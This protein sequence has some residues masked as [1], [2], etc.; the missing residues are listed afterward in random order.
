MKKI[1]NAFS[2]SGNQQCPKSVFLGS[3]Y[4]WHHQDLKALIVAAIISILLGIPVSLIFYI[5]ADKN[6]DVSSECS[7]SAND[8]CG[9]RCTVKNSGRKNAENTI[10][11]FH[12]ILP[13]GTVVSSKPEYNITL[14]EQI[15]IPDP[16]KNPELAFDFNSITVE[17]PNIPSGITVDFNIFTTN[18]EN[19]KA[20]KYL[21]K[22][23]E[24][25][26]EVVN[27]YGEKLKTNRQELYVGWDTVNNINARIKRNNLYRPRFVHYENGIKEINFLT[28]DEIAAFN[29]SFK[30]KD[31]L[32][33]GYPDISKVAQFY[34]FPVISVKTGSGNKLFMTFPEFT[35]I[36][37]DS[38]KTKVMDFS[39][40]KNL[41]PSEIVDGN[42]LRFQLPLI[43]PETYS[44]I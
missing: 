41:K 33:D 7:V 27:L 38:E 23:M 13:D 2:K 19:Q 42:T 32:M 21:S 11:S 22:I 4:C 14:H 20:C 44:E 34:N 35:T 3:R 8:Y 16:N 5:L 30:V 40:Y 26:S 39:S 6:A 18:K 12:G 29:S 36:L 25:V 37:V 24:K 28:E 10:L 31:Y 1:C 15:G 43:Q 17:I 9:M